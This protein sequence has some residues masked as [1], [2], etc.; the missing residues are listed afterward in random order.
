MAYA[1]RADPWKK[2]KSVTRAYLAYRNAQAVTGSLQRCRGLFTLRVI[3]RTAY[4]LL[5]TLLGGSGALNVDLSG[6][7]NRFGQYCDSVVYNFNESAARRIR[8]ALAIG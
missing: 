8:D 7:L 1:T 5:C 2:K 6:R 4:R 3:Q